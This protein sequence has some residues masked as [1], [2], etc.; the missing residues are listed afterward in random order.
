MFA[1]KS[2]QEWQKSGKDI[3]SVIADPQFVN[4][5]A[6]DF[7]FK[8]SAVVKKIKFIPFDYSKAGV[9]GA[10]EWKRLADFDPALARKFDERVHSMEATKR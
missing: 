3:H 7:H 1:D 2:F 10:E 9:Y 6:F 4:A 5:A 8:K